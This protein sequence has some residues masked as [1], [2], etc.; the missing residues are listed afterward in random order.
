MNENHKKLIKITLDKMKE[1]T[2]Q[3]PSNIH[4]KE[5][6]KAF[7]IHFVNNK[8]PLGEF[9]LNRYPNGIDYLTN[10]HKRIYDSFSTD[11]E[12]NYNENISVPVKLKDFKFDVVTNKYTFILQKI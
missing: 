7:E 3:R 12:K 8:T 2:G 4:I 10:L 1:V 5:S 11:L 9:I 6:E